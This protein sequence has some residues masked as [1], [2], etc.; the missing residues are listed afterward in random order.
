M[1]CWMTATGSLSSQDSSMDVVMQYKTIISTIRR[2]EPMSFWS[3]SKIVGL[4]QVMLWEEEC[5]VRVPEVNLR[6]ADNSPCSILCFFLVLPNGKNGGMVQSSFQNRT[7]HSFQ[8]VTRIQAPSLPLVHA[9]VVG[10]GKLGKWPWTTTVL[11]QFFRQCSALCLRVHLCSH[12]V[13]ERRG[14]RMSNVPRAQRTTDSP[15]GCPG[16]QQVLLYITLLWVFF[17]LDSLLCS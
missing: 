1:P 7:T 11:W 3:K 2:E 16:I 12:H 6:K 14:P 5:W 17:N 13:T 9:D 15:L 4:R 10:G 8:S